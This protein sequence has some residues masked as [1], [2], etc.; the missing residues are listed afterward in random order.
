MKETQLIAGYARNYKGELVIAVHI[1]GRKYRILLTREQF[2]LV[3]GFKQSKVRV[4]GM[5]KY[6]KWRKTR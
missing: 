4:L 5:E 6:L 1:P 2:P 3:F